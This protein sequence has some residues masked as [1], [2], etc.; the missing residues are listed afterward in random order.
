MCVCGNPFP[1]FLFWAYAHPPAVYHVCA[2]LTFIFTDRGNT[3][4]FSSVPA[5]SQ[6][7][8]KS[9]TSFWKNHAW[10]WGIPE[11]GASTSSTRWEWGHEVGFLPQKMS[12]WTSVAKE[13][14]VMRKNWMNNHSKIQEREDEAI[15]LW[16]A[17]HVVLSIPLELFGRGRYCLISS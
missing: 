12:L 2:F 1:F 15:W 14:N 3:L 11:R 5:G 10:W 13:H 16:K 6:M 17:G 8:G 7:V 4:R 9:P